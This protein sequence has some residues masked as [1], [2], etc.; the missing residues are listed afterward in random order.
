MAAVLASLG[1]AMLGMTLMFNSA[2]QRVLVD[3]L[4]PVGVML[5]ATSSV[6]CV[7][8]IVRLVDHSQPHTDHCGRCQ[9]YQPASG[10]YQ[11]GVCGRTHNPTMRLDTCINY[12]YSE[13]AM[14]RDRFCEAAHVLN[15]FSET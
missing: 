13:R 1:V 7:I 2:D 11:H 14:V 10:F 15:S 3:S 5:L 6:P 12:T 9:F 8:G 4:V